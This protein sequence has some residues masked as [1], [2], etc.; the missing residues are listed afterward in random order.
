MKK[1]IV[2]IGFGRAGKRFLKYIKKNNKI[3]ILKIIVKKKRNIYFKKKN[4]S[5][6]Y[7]DI[8]NLHNIDGAIIATPIKISFK[9]AKLFLKKKIPILIEKPFC[10]T[11][12]QSKELEKLSKRKKS[13]FIINYSDL[14]DPK[15]VQLL[16]KGSKRIG[17]IKEI[18]ANYGN[19]K[20]LYPVKNK[21]YPIQNWISHP[22][23]TLIKICGDLS[24][25]RI[26]SY[27]LKIKNRLFFEK[28]QIQI[29]KNKLKLIFNFSNYPGF[30]NRN[31]KII[32]KKGYLRF[33]SYKPRD[34]YFFYKKK[35]LIISK[36]SSIE[37]VLHLFLKTIDKNNK[38][39]NLNIGVKEH[40]LSNN[41]L[42][43]LSKVRSKNI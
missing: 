11:I 33:N 22:I 7:S 39:S 19:N 26:N 30:K 4:V 3:E 31:I 12:L 14:F 13:S 23:S 6:T 15:L 25:F 8:K 36:I 41:I 42:K 5:G 16:N 37:N 24:S 28:V 29:L 2:L 1:K 32:G 40:F 21:F 18:V 34:N 20:T 9:Y 43:S 10:E 27:K 35:N 38:I 17:K